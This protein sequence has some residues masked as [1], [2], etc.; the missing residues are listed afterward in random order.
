MQVGHNL[1]I[2]KFFNVSWILLLFLSCANE[3]ENFEVNGQEIF[4]SNCIQCHGLKGNLQVSGASDLTKSNLSEE[5][6][7][8]FI[9][10]GRNAM[11]PYEKLLTESQIN[12]VATYVQG[13]RLNK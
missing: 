5:Q 12:A 13:L 3:P 8:N 9:K 11:I 6:I 10:K 4:E 1:T 7:I 2:M